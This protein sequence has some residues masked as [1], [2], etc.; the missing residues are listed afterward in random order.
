MTRRAAARNLLAWMAGSPLLRSQGGD[1]LAALDD[2]VNVFEFE[3]VF[4]ARVTRGAYDFVTGGA[5]DEWTV[6]RNRDAFQRFTLQ[7]RFLT[8]VSQLDLSLELYGQRV[9]MPILVSPTGAQGLSH[10]EGELAM[11]R[12]AGAAHTIMCV[13]TNS[14]F[15]IDK[16]AG[17]ATGPLWFQLYAGPDRDA[18]RE[19]VERAVGAGCK[20]V[21]FTIDSAYSPYRERMLRNRV[22]QPVPPGGLAPQPGRRPRVPQE[23]ARYGLRPLLVAELTWSYL[24]QLNSYAKVPVL[25]KGILSPQDARLAVERGAAGVIVSNHGGRYLDT[26]PST[27]EVLPEIVDAVAGK[28]P[29]LIDG[30]IRRGTDVLVALA[31]GAKAVMVGRPPLWGLGSFGA[32]GVERVLEL[33]QTELA[34]AMGQSGRPTLASIDRSLVRVSP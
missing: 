10:A 13:S 25:L 16:I 24:D 30:G 26:A 15:P 31:L 32:P 7:P 34:R 23:P 4:R 20:T 22:G 6:R 1:R 8:D 14:S 18:T 17:A 11:A 29:V 2:L 19:K 5:D 33:L 28:I 3:P 12:G 27:I 21:C 9:E